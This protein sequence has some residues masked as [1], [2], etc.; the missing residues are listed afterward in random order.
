[1]LWGLA[2]ALTGAGVGICWP[3]LLTRIL[4]L[5]PVDEGDTASAAITTIQLYGIAIGAAMA[6]LLANAAGLGEPGGAEGARRAA[7]V[8]FAAFAL[9]PGLAALLAGRGFAR[10]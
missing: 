6:G 9:A 5:A 3:H 10:R 7:V 2:L 1:A 4:T 8:L